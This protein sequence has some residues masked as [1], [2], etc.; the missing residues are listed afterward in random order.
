MHERRIRTQ[1]R[2]TLP[3]SA[4]EE[5]WKQKYAR[6]ALPSSV[7]GE[8]EMENING[9]FDVLLSKYCTD[10]FLWHKPFSSGLVYTIKP[11]YNGTKN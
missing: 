6:S 8:S 11:H 7:F 5:G 9:D 4:K 1:N 2:R 10:I 3:A